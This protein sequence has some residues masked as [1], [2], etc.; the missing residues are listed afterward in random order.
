M[1]DNKIIITPNLNQNKKFHS[2]YYTTLIGLPNSG[3]N[4]MTSTWPYIKLIQFHLM[5]HQRQIWS[6]LKW[7]S[8]RWNFQFNTKYQG[9]VV[10]H[11]NY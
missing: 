2:A 1:I 3:P 9:S 10:S 8:K 11:K 4:T 7:G 5:K 6:H